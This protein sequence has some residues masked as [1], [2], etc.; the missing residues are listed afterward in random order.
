MSRYSGNSIAKIS[1]AGLA[2]LLWAGGA[3][4]KGF[5]VVYNFAG[6][7]DSA[8]PEAG[9]IE[10]TAGNFYG[11]TTSGGAGAGTVFK[12]APDGSETVLYS[13]TDQSDGGIPYGNLVRDQNGNIYGTT[14]SGGSFPCNCGVI[15]KIDSSEQQTVLHAFLGGSDGAFPYGG[16]LIEDAQGNLYG[17]TYNG[18][19]ADCFDGCGT[20]FKL[21]PDG[22]ETVLHAFAGGSDGANP[23]WGPVMDKHGNLYGATY[24]GGGS[25]VCS[26]G[27]GTVYKIDSAGNE[28]VIFAFPGGSGGAFP[29]TSLVMDRQGNLY[30]TTR[31]GGTANGGTVFKLAPDGTETVLHSF[32]GGSDGASPYAGLVRDGKGNLYGTTQQGGSADAGVVFKVTSTGAETVLYSFGGG[33][34][35]DQPVAPLLIGAD[36]KLYGTASEGGTN[37]F[38]TVF[39]L[40]R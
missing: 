5:K 13:F 28:S 22:T 17:A 24:A 33:T 26:G 39:S 12:L 31:F 4:A 37:G 6:G 11:T 19:G 21:A 10:D 7:T 20:V 34:D 15:F 35:G 27:C 23:W 30:G 2:L 40:K 36:K 29:Q 8:V 9:L 14:N 25:A 18:G 16:G 3:Q 1:V 38:G 32:P